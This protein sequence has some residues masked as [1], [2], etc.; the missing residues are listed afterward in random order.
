MRTPPT[1]PHQHEVAARSAGIVRNIDNRKLARAAK[2]AG[3][4]DAPASGLQFWVPIGTRV[5]RGQPLFTLHAE[6]PGE[7]QYALEYIEQHPNIID[8]EDL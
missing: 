8:L 7:M 6:T 3:A 1:A 2:L 5:E 4:P